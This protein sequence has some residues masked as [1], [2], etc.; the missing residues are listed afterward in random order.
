MQFEAP[1]W[2]AP[3]GDTHMHATDESLLTGLLTAGTFTST[4]PQSNGLST[5][6]TC[7]RC[8]GR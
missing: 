7:M 4:K 5:L 8:S 1:N 2:D 6:S 3:S